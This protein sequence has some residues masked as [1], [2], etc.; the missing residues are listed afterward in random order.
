MIIPLIVAPPKP[1]CDF[2]VLEQDQSSIEFTWRMDSTGSEIT[3]FFIEYCARK[4]AP[5]EEGTRVSGKRR[6][7]LN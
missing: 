6:Y 4:D 7:V 2:H 5:W 1:P 3:K